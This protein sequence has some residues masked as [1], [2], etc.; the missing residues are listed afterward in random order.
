MEPQD[1]DRSQKEKNYIECL[2]IEYFRAA[3]DHMEAKMNLTA[4]HGQPYGFLS[5]G[6]TIAFAETIAGYASNQ[7]LPAEKKAVGQSVSANHLKPKKMGGYIIAKGRLL[8]KGR[9][10]H[11]W[12]IEVIDDHNNLISFI[13]VI[14]AI[15][16]IT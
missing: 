5:G 10:S 12:S 2:N 11:A 6:V 7:L 4:F 15:I 3:G 8:H 13:T 14:N 9:S 1:E 16:K